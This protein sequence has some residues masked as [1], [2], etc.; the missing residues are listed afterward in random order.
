MPGIGPYGP[1][2]GGPHGHFF[3]LPMLRGRKTGNS[4]GG[5]ESSYAANT[6]VITVVHADGTTEKRTVYIS[7]ETPTIWTKIKRW[8]KR[9]HR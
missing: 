7:N 2:Y 1:M 3:F 5:S 4:N 8:W 9:R 6:R